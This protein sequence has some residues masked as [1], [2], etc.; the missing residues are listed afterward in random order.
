MT[1]FVT[2]LCTVIFF[3]LRRDFMLV[4]CW[5]IGKEANKNL[6]LS[7]YVHSD[8]RDYECYHMFKAFW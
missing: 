1:S 8:T 6:F 2:V 5:H 4:C 7:F 3:Y